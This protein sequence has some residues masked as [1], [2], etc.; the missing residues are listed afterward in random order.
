VSV[1][2]PLQDER[3]SGV[4]CVRA[5]TKQTVHPESYEVIALAPGENTKIER[6]VRPL[7]RAHDR[8]LT[9]PG[10]DEY[11]LFE[12]GGRTPPVSTSS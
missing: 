9:R 11:E 3:E 2:L 8:W 7:L 10:H 1:L 4:E 6:A 12:L 5:W